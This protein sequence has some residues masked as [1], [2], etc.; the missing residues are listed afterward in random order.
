V[1]KW[2]FGLALLGVLSGGCTFYTSC[3]DPNRGPAGAGATTSGGGSSSSGG[4][5]SST[6]GSDSTPRVAWENVTNNLAGLDSACGNLTLLQAKSDNVILAGVSPN[7]LFATTDGGDSWNEIA[8]G[9]GTQPINGGVRTVTLD[10][11]NPDVYWVSCIYG[12]QGIW[13]TDDNGDTF[14]ILGSIK[15][16]DLVDLDFSDPERKVLVAGGHET[17]KALWRSVDGGMNWDDIGSNLPDD[18]RSSS[19]PVVLGPELHL[20]GAAGYGDGISGIFR[21]EDGGATWERVSTIGG[22]GKPLVLEDGTIYWPGD[23]GTLNRST[24]QGLNWEEVLPKDSVMGY[25]SVLQLPDGRLAIIG[26]YDGIKISSDGFAKW[27]QLTERPP[28]Y[29]AGFT[30]SVPNQAF[31]IWHSDC[32]NKVL[33]DAVMRVKFDYTT[34]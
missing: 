22:Y 31:Y 30:Y 21:T 15:Y 18:S 5:S 4:G 27:Q 24:D 9:K 6:G 11:S 7:R 33:D 32:G 17:S 26:L 34:Q 14:K 23:D 28:F 20:L 12:Q 29:S 16:N 13:R 10:P 2:T 8:Q 19:Y 25:Q 3:P 1:Q